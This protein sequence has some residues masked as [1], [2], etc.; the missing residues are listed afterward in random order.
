MFDRIYKTC[1][2]NKIEANLVKSSGFRFDFRLVLLR[3]APVLLQFIREE[4]QRLFH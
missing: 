4:S 3:F 1:R 2:I